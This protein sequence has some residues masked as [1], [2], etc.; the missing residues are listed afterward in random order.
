MK[1]DILS[2]IENIEIYPIIS[3]LIFVI[4]FV[5]MFIWVIRVDKKYIDHMKEMPFDDESPKNS[6]YEKV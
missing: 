1:K 6:G 2:S 5:G 4:F 3:L